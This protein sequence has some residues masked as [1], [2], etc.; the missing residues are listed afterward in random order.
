VLRKQRITRKKKT[1]HADERD[2]PD[3]QAQRATFTKKLTAVDPN[4][5]F[6]SMNLG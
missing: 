1:L 5:W 4:T 2:R 6:L 3:V